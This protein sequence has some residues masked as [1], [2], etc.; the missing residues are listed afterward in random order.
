MLRG[1]YHF[2]D[3]KKI[4]KKSKKGEREEIRRSP[5]LPVSRPNGPWIVSTR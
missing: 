3:P 4:M 5:P 2:Y 1:I